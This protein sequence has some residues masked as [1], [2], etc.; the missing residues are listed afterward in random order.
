MFKGLSSK[1]MRYK[2]HSACSDMSNDPD[3]QSM[4]NSS[5][6]KSNNSSPKSQVLYSAK[7]NSF[8]GELSLD[9]KNLN[10][11]VVGIETLNGRVHVVRKPSQKFQC[12]ESSNELNYYESPAPK[13]S[14]LSKTN[15]FQ[16]S[17]ALDMLE[18]NLASTESAKTLI[19]RRSFI[20]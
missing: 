20:Q 2:L 12:D 19:R 16:S 1:E 8:L 4:K 7:C 17:G 14:T 18:A 3:Y 9:Y 11:D 15:M 13:L 5:S 10:S 6:C